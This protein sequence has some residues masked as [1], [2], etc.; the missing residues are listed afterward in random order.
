VRRAAGHYG[1]ID[2]LINNAGISHRSPF[3]QTGLA[4][5]RRV[6]DVN[7]LGA[8]QLTHSALPHLV[9]SRGA[10]ATI[11]SVAG[12]SPL[13]ARTGYAASKHALHGFFGSLRSELR[14]QGID[15][16]LVCPSF[17]A[18]A[19][20]RNALGADGQSA[21]H[22]QVVIGRRMTPEYVA[23]R[24]AVGMSRRR[25]LLLIG[26]TAHQAWWLSRLAP[27]LFE[28]IMVHRLQGEM[29]QD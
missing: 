15:V 9:Q 13:I 26:A 25:P 27:S 23:D 17:I 10:I 5:L 1:R 4:V 21:R 8:V 18:T 14:T 12:F 16:T 22:A 29:Q 2:V 24:I 20:D 28:R 19:I 6:M 11:S 3:A 7:F